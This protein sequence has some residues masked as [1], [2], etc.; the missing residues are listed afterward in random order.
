MKDKPIAGLDRCRELLRR[1]R[2]GFAAAALAFAVTGCATGAEALGGPSLRWTMEDATVFPADRSL[3]HAEDGVVLPDGRLLVGDWLHGLVALSPNGTKR[4][5][6]D[7]AAAGFKT[8]PAPD[9]G[10]PNGIS[11][12]PDQRHVLVADI[13]TGA[14]YR[15]DTETETVRRL[16]DHPYGVNAAVRDSTGAIWFTQSTQNPEGEGSEARMFAAVEG[17]GD[18]AVYRI[19]PGETGNAR[20]FATRVVD[21][22]DFANGIAVDERRGRLYVNEVAGNR[23]LSFPVDLVSG[24]LGTKTVFANIVSP[25]NVELDEH[26]HLWIASPLGNEVVVIDPDTGVVTPVFQPSPEAGAA[27]KAEMSRRM[28]TGE[29]ILALLSPSV[30]GPMPGLVTGVILS[31]GK[32][33]VYVTG[34]GGALIRLDRRSGED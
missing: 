14:I 17:I 9:W 2:S 7:F 19:A 32:G 18:G 12:E 4:P 15:V 25:D 11:F 22:L 33:P 30:W 3:T 8:K 20:P 6:G 23:V 5:F 16:Y 29:S 1:H 10:S 34:L 31:P 26:G 21:G 13:T 28:E 24:K 27:M